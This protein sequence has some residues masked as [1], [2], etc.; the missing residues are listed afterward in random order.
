MS[1]LKELLK[2]VPV[3]WKA[4]GKITR[5][6][7]GRRLTKNQLSTEG[8]PVYHG[9]L[10]PLGYYDS[11]NRPSNSVMIINVGASAGNVGISPTDFRSEEHTSE[12]QSRENL[13]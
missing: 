10:E 11:F 13:V 8:Y 12:L 5:V 1:T 6:L 7:R 3:E 4:L 9:G 2:D